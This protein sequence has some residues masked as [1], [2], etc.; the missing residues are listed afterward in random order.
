LFAPGTLHHDWQ[1]IDDHIQKAADQQRKYECGSDKQEWRLDEYGLHGLIA[2][3]YRNGV[4]RR[5]FIIFACSRRDQT[6]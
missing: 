6:K 1:A 3:E 5:R 2:P 4:L